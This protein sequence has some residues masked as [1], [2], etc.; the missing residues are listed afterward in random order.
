MTELFDNVPVPL[1][2]VNGERRVRRANRAALQLVGRP[3][4]AV[5]GRRGGEVLACM[6]SLDDPQ[7]C[8]FGDYCAR[9]PVRLAV[10]ETIETG[11]GVERLVL[12]FP[13]RGE[14][15]PQ[16]LKFRLSTQK[17]EGESG[18]GALVF[19]EDITDQIRTEEAL[20]GLRR[21][22]A[23]W[24]QSSGGDSA[25][26]AAA[27]AALCTMSAGLAHKENNLLQAS[28]GELEL[29][30]A[31]LTPGSALGAGLKRLRDQ[32]ITT[33]GLVRAL[34]TFTG[35]LPMARQMV[36][37][38]GLAAREDERRRLML[39]PTVGLRLDLPDRAAWVV[40]DPGL[41]RQALNHL[42]NNAVEA[43]ETRPGAVTLELAR[44]SPGEDPNQ[45]LCGG[46]TLGGGSW[47][48]LGVADDG[49]GMDGA[50]CARA[51]Q[52]FFT[53]HLAGRGLGLAECWGIARAHGGGL[54]LTGDPGLGV[55]AWLILPESV[56]PAP[57]G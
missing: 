54:G 10:M 38:T 15:G 2:E 14:D 7:G 32:L 24:R 40:G 4:A 13:R 53:T 12:D 25:A 22:M 20:D 34:V 51:W 30:F 28:L 42:L 43:L 37:L 49:I 5:L 31:H 21:E 29:G 17:V 19:I 26:Q 16:T 45:G 23:Q 39:P 50:T 18:P 3:A 44:L 11:R 46:A 47:L 9:C 1:I 33:A 6:H 41:L 57:G 55:R 36:D 56:A 8:G 52:P 27:A 35:H 48:R